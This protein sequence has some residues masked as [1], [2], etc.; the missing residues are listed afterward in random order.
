M[1][2]KTKGNKMLSVSVTVIIFVAV[3]SLVSF[4]SDTGTHVYG[5]YSVD[6]HNLYLMTARQWAI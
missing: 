4:N 1:D 6:Q 2:N 3:T 5:K